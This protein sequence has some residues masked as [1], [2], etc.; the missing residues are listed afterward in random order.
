VSER[1]LRRRAVKILM[2][3]AWMITISLQPTMGVA[4]HRFLAFPNIWFKR[5]A[6][7]RTAL[8]AAASR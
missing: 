1:H 3:F 2:S 6:S 4:W 5:E 8:G 7:G